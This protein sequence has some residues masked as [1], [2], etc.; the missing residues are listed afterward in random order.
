MRRAVISSSSSDDSNDASTTEES[1]PTTA[2]K[3]DLS[4]Q[5]I[6]ARNREKA[7]QL[8]AAKRSLPQ[9]PSK[10]VLSAY[11]DTLVISVTYCSVLTAHYVVNMY[12]Y[13]THTAFF[14]FAMP[15]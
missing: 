6:I 13:G 9:E 10:L 14:T 7:L 15:G 4:Q 3:I 11:I 1:K 8:R 2:A 12:S 5:E